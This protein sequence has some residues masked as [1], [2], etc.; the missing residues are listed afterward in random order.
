MAD[1]LFALLD[2]GDPRAVRE[3]L[4]RR[5][6][7]ALARDTEGLSAVRHAAYRGAELLAAVLAAQ[8]PLDGFDAALVGDLERLAEPE[9]WSEDGFSALHLAVFGRQVEAAQALLDRGA[10]PEALARHADPNLR[11]RPLHTATAFGGDVATARTLLDG[12][13][14]PNGRSAGGSTPLHNAAQVGNR[15]LVELLL[16]RGADPAIRLPDGRTAAAL[17]P[18]EELAALLGT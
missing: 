4:A 12:G 15:E 3:L 5:P 17:A 16:E 7:A 13:A 8:P 11:I 14:D 6:E 9:A 18:G 2:R 10:D 1:E